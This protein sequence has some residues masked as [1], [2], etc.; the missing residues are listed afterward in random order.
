[1]D[2][3][4]PW[5][6]EWSDLVA[7]L[8]FIGVVATYANFAIS[9]TAKDSNRADFEKLTE[10]IA[11][12]NETMAKVNMVL[13]SLKADRESTNRRLDKIEA[14]TDRHDIQLARIEEHVMTQD[15]K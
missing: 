2:I 1:M 6:F 15:S 10:S 9:H 14:T 7:I 13:D 12:L 3:H 8:T 5:G 11:K 4:H